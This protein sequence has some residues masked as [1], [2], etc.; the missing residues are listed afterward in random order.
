MITLWGDHEFAWMMKARAPTDSIDS[1]FRPPP[2]PIHPTSHA[3]VEI[4]SSSRRE[5]VFQAAAAF[6]AVAAVSTPQPASA[7]LGFG[8]DKNKLYTD[9]TSAVIEQVRTTIQLPMGDEGRA[10]SIE[11]TRTMTNQWV[12]KYRRNKGISGKPSYG[13]VYSGLNAVSGHFNNFGTKYPLTAKRLERVLKEFSDAEL[14]LSRG[15]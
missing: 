13:N 4:A 10:A 8:E 14:A 3:Q 12:A 5:V 2:L 1:P 11:K 15:R 9:D 7:F 6:A